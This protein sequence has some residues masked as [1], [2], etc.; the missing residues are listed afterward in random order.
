VRRR[1]PLAIIAAVLLVLAGTTHAEGTRFTSRG[2]GEG[3][4]IG[5]S[6]PA[7]APRGTESRAGGP[8]MGLRVG[9]MHRNH[10]WTVPDWADQNKSEGPSTGWLE[11]GLFAGSYPVAFK[12]TDTT[13]LD[14][15]GWGALGIAV[16]RD[17]LLGF[18]AGIV[19][20]SLGPQVGT[21][22]D[23][24]ALI[25]APYVNLGINAMLFFGENPD[26][27]SLLIDTLYPGVNDDGM[28][29]DFSGVDRF[30]YGPEFGLGVD[31][32]I[33]DSKMTAGLGVKWQSHKFENGDQM[34]DSWND[35]IGQR[36]IYLSIGYRIDL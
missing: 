22:F 3:G 34:W 23:T 30:S 14:V 10:E 4:N 36:T 32:R 21:S 25:V 26:G 7:E 1:L 28:T 24:G 16:P 6:I 11:L 19:S 20:L 17:D 27:W 18:N 29:P 2:T 9:T 13:T 31:I 8:F 15:G 35:S 5:P 33:P 12:V